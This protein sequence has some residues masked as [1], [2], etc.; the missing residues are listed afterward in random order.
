MIL[1]ILGSIDLASAVILLFSVYFSFIS[2]KII[3]LIA[4]YLLLKGTV[5]L[6]SKDI[7]SILDILCAII[8]LLSMNFEL[9]VVFTLL[10]IFYLFQ[11]GVLSL[12]S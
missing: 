1:K 10:I 2:D 8:L 3:L 12:V 9:N 7:A 6:I 5:F 4:I 11:K